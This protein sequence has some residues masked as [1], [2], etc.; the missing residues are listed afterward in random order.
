MLMSHRTDPMS[1]FPQAAHAALLTQEA[2][3]RVV[4]PGEAPAMAAL[5]H[6]ALKEFTGRPDVAKGAEH[7]TAPRE[8]RIPD[9]APAGRGGV[10]D[11]RAEE[12]TAADPG[13][14]ANADLDLGPGP[15]T[16]A[17]TYADAGL[18]AGAAEFRGQ[19][20]ER[21]AH[22]ARVVRR[23]FDCGCQLTYSSDR[24]HLGWS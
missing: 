14:E 4:L 15:G 11:L 3:A 1:G 2:T 6:E 5:G 24:T 7:F 12:G 13:A 18:D 10:V 23:V 19:Q 16:T 9:R 8:A 20:C 17:N 21:T 22:G